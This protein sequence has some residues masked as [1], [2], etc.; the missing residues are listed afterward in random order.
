MD[1]RTMVN[2]TYYTA[3][4]TAIM[5]AEAGNEDA[6]RMAADLKLWDSL[7]HSRE[8]E[9]PFPEMELQALLAGTRLAIEARY[10]AVSHL[11]KSGEYQS[12]LDVGCGYTPRAVDCARAGIDYVGLDVPVVAEKLQRYAEASGM[13]G[14]HPVYM[15]G[16]A[17]N[18]SSLLR[19]ARPLAGKLLISSEGL[20]HYLSADEAEQLIIG[21]QKTLESHGGAWVTSDFGLSIDSFSIANMRDPAAAALYLKTRSEITEEVQIY[22]NGVAFWEEERKLAFLEDHGMLVE[23]LPLYQEGEALQS[24]HAIAEDKRET[25]RSLL[26]A[27]SI[28]RMT[29]DPA[30]SNAVQGSRQVDHLIVDYRVSGE[31][32]FF[33]TKGRVDTLTAPILLEIF[34]QNSQGI[35]SV[36]IDAMQLQYI[37]S[38]GLR[39]LLIMVK[40]LGEGSVRLVGA[41]DAVKEIFHATGFDQMIIVK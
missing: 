25:M 18:T 30:F 22:H 41:P 11:L 31:K 8:G 6:K 10:A 3:K 15:G 21:I 35:R 2:P 28:W 38:A 27:A 29:A 12:L 4:T 37:S 13:G 36:T 40:K 14:G 7:R 1:Y 19:A 26:G 16:D 23:K 34:D 9:V 24:M 17:T 33:M 32:L 20:L 39:T 5:L